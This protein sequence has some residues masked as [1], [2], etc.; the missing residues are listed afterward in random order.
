MYRRWGKRVFDVGLA[1]VLVAL[2]LPL[3]LLLVVVLA[4]YWQGNP[5]FWQ[6]RPGY[7]EKLFWIVKFKTLRQGPGTDA[8]RLTPLGA[9]LRRT[10][11]DE[12]PQLWQVL[13]GQ[14]ACVGPRPY[15]VAYVPL[16]TERQRLRHQVRPGIT[17]WAQVN[18]RNALGWP[19]RLELDVYYV[20]H[21]S[22]G[23][24]LAI[25]WRSVIYLVRGTG[26]Q[27]PGEVT[28]RIFTGTPHDPQ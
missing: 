25:L 15:L 24:D 7:R 9:W 4:V 10:S 2:T 28:G 22:L 6:L 16:Y 11:L 18:G 14:M 1:L 12:L 26:V 19:E 23:L 3:Q 27:S 5:L 8:E 21:L 13:T 20:E 17:G